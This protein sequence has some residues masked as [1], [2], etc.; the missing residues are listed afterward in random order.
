MARLMK[1]VLLERQEECSITEPFMTVP[2][3][4]LSLTPRLR[5]LPTAWE[6][7]VDL[8]EGRVCLL[9]VHRDSIH[10]FSLL[11]AKHLGDTLAKI[12]CD[13]HLSCRTCVN[14]HL[15]KCNTPPGNNDMAISLPLKL[16]LTLTLHIVG[17]GNRTSS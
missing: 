7:T 5:S 9:Q 8:E 15:K 16:M 6:K 10:P 2:L 12:Q 11:R 4:A 13:L 14:K 1:G 17:L 3:C